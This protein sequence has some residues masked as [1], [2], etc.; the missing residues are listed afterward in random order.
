MTTAAGGAGGAGDGN[1]AGDG[2]S[3]RAGEPP[4]LEHVLETCLYAAN[5][6]AAVEF[7]ANVLGLT[8]VSREEGRHAFF[9]CG[10]QM[11]LVFDPTATAAPPSS[12]GKTPVPL[13]GAHGPGHVAFAIDA[14]HLAAWRRQ[15]QAHAIAIECEVSWPRGGRSLYVRDPGGNSVELAM[16]VMWGL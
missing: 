6:D 1:G 4:P 16:P 10:R 9:R 13:H 12:P 8:L 3:D 14:D 11:L 15:L 5:L 2:A 7:Y